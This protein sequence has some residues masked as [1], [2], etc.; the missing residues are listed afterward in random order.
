[1]RPKE[2]AGQAM[3]A[4]VWTHWLQQDDQLGLH[5]SVGFE[6]TSLGWWSLANHLISYRPS[7]SWGCPGRPK[8]PTLNLLWAPLS[9]AGGS[10]LAQFLPAA[11]QLPLPS[12]N[13]ATWFLPD[14]SAFGLFFPCL[15]PPDA[16]GFEQKCRGPGLLSS[17]SSHMASSSYPCEDKERQRDSEPEVTWGHAEQ[18]RFP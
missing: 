14:I 3:V 15:I 6:E 18:L 7:S 5:F 12:T 8:M 17:F 16:G 13:E 4:P 11:A 2:S 9:M 1:M 10:G